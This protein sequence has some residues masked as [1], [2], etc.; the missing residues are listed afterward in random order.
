MEPRFF[1]TSFFMKSVSMINKRIR[2]YQNEKSHITTLFLQASIIAVKQENIVGIIALVII[3]TLGFGQAYAEEFKVVIPFGAYDPTF[4]TPAENWY[5]L[6]VISIKEGDTVTWINDDREGHTVT[7]G[8]GAGRFGWMSG[9]KFGEPTGF[10]DSGRFNPSESWTYTFEKAGLF[11]YFCTIHPWMEGVII[12]GELIPD[13]PHDA[14][15][16]KIERFPVIEYTGDELIE[17][18]LTWEPN[19]ITTHEKVNFIFQTYDP[20]T[21]SNLD[22]MKYDFIIIQNG[23]EIYRDVGLTSVGGDY[24]NYIFDKPGPIEIRFENIVSGGTSAIENMARTLPED[25]SLRMVS[26]TTMVYDNPEKTIHH[27]IV[28]QPAK[29]VELQYEILVAIIIAPAGL[30][31]GAILY[32]M[33][34]K[35]KA[36]KRTAI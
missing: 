1:C 32:M 19:V 28:V 5:E 18:D 15:G 33:Y 14:F 29:R 13:Y 10:F 4:E 22:K 26:F 36:K 30:A 2:Q 21:N 16:K 27:D 12:V 7:S 34:S 24:R 11:N 3:C 8:K 17:M 6:P 23:E 35:Q 9:N 31:I 25:P 20:A